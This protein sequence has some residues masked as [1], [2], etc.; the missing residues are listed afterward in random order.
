MKNPFQRSYAPEEIALFDFLSEINLFHDLN[1]DEKLTFLPYMYLRKYKKDEAVF[2]RGDPSHALYL[3]K[4]G[5]VQLMLDIDQDTETLAKVQEKESFGNSALIHDAKRTHSAIVLSNEAGLYVIPH[6]NIIDIFRSNAK[7]K[8][9]MLSS[10]AQAYE[11]YIEDMF[12]SYRTSKGF[13]SINQ[14]KHTI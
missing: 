11:A 13:F 4:S 1:N 7:I 6:V 8:A 2:F 12:D 10:L 5:E 9:K 3:V 14:L